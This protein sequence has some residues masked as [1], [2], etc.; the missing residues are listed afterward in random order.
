MP[1]LS[2]GFLTN[3]LPVD[4]EFVLHDMCAGVLVQSYIHV[5]RSAGTVSFL[6]DLPAVTLV[7]S[8]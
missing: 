1:G 8:S 5:C 4:G 2:A 6:P 7:G 3:R